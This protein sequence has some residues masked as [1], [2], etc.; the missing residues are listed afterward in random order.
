ML[1]K[2]GVAVSA[3]WTIKSV[4]PITQEIL[5]LIAASDFIVAIIGEQSRDGVMYELGVARSLGKPAFVVLAGG[6]L[7]S[8]LSGIFVRAIENGQIADVSDDLDRFL[9]NAKAPRPI[10]I[11]PPK[12]RAIDM[13]WARAQLAELRSSNVARGEALEMLVKRIFVAANAEVEDVEKFSQREQVDFV[14]WLNEVAFE[15]GGPILVECKVLRGGSG[16]VIKNAETYVKRLKRTVDESDASLA[17]L[18]YDHDR[19]SAPPALYESPRVLSFAVDSLIDSL[20]KGTLE[21]EILNRRRRA[22]FV[23]GSGS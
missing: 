16:S 22:A 21:S 8:D 3:P 1:I 18:V 5:S 4:A 23:S 14:V 12:G 19:P 13:K 10:S 11:G 20:E 17:I 6:R 9:R 15:A 7:S 2:K